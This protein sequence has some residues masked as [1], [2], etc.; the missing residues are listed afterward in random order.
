MVCSLSWACGQGT[1]KSHQ[2][3]EAICKSD[4]NCKTV[5]LRIN[6]YFCQNVFDNYLITPPKKLLILEAFDMTIGLVA[7]T[8]G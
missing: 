5:T 1:T 3:N 7:I 8:C 2:Q 6:S 4:N